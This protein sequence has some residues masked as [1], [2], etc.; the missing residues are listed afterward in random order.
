MPII[1]YKYYLHNKTFTEGHEW[2]RTVCELRRVPLHSTKG[3]GIP[4]VV[5][6]SEW[7]ERKPPY[8]VRTAPKKERN[9]ALNHVS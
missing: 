3:Y 1:G 8:F 4:E 9:R 7:G 2:N 5:P 6:K